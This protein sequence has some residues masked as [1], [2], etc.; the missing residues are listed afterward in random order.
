MKRERFE[1]IEKQFAPS[2]ELVEQ[3]L[4]KA[5]KLSAGEVTEKPM[6][7]GI[8]MKNNIIRKN[9]TIPIV[10]AAASLSSKL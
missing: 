10:T 8:I 5:E 3:V 7:G 6:E 1:R 9:R 2:D 4:A